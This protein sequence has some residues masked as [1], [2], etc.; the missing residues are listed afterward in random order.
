MVFLF[1]ISACG[2]RVLLSHLC[3]HTYLTSFFQS[4]AIGCSLSLSCLELG[5]F[6][7]SCLHRVLMVVCVTSN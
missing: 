7:F 1:L 2:E 5:P 4:L 3:C 6:T